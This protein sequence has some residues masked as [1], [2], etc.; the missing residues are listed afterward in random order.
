MN[1]FVVLIAVF[2][3]IAGA[4]L[5]APP[6]NIATDAT[7]S[8]L[9][10][11]MPGDAERRRPLMTP[12]PQTLSPDTKSGADVIVPAACCKVCSKGKPCGNS[13]IA[14]DRTCTR[15]PGCAC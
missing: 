12:A 6:K 4:A 5:A 13:C 7:A 3:V 9:S 15:P 11:P 2:G 10:A 1:R 8:V 14:R